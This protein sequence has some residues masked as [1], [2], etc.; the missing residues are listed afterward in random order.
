VFARWLL[1]VGVAL[2]ALLTTLPNF[3]TDESAPWWP[4]WLPQKTL[5][6]GL[7]LQ[8]GAHLALEVDLADLEQ[9]SY[10]N[11]E[12]Q[13][14]TIL[15]QEQLNYRNLQTRNGTV[16][17]EAFKPEQQA[18]VERELKRQLRDADVRR[19]GAT[20]T[21]TFTEQFLTQLRARALAQT[22]EIL[23]G[24]VDE[25]GVA[26]PLIQQQGERRIIVQLPGIEDIARA[27]GIIGRTAQ[28]SFYLV[29]REVDPYG[30]IPPGFKVLHEE[31]TDPAS[32]EVT[33]RLPYV[34]PQRP[35]LTGEYLTGAT[36][37]FDQFGQPAVMMSFDGR[38]T[39]LFARL[40]SENVGRQFAIVLDGVVYSAPVFNEAILGGRAQI[41]GNF[42]VQE[43]ED[44]ATV[45]RAGALPAPVA[46]VEERTVGPSLG[47][48]SVQA[49]LLAIMIGFVLVL[50]V[51][52]IFYF[53]YGLM[54]NTALL[55][56]VLLIT[57][58]MSM[59]GATLTLPGM[60]G[61]VL[62][63]GIAVDANVLIFERIREELLGG[64]SPR[65]AIQGGFEKALSTIVDANITTLMTA[66]IL[67]AVGSGPLRGFALT[68]GIGILAS[69]F[70]AIVLTRLLMESWLAVR[71]PK[72]ISL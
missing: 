53:G 64:R 59:L 14:R 40:S 12:A 34:V 6:L 61:I 49:G 16:T 26:E 44:L 58:V 36:A 63:I 28:L 10:E 70:T 48:D 11:L 21:L 32:G 52:A 42:T 38:G 72:Q 62:T 60:A 13:V 50:G 22:V 51:M 17:L 27:K 56:N 5:T 23:R 2:L 54:A 57:G 7:D 15:R 4:N 41:T 8:G 67:F 29:N 55:V 20:V 65:G 18:E 19:D 45:L 1:V 35:N 39:Q 33:Q 31:F 43:A 66:V 3:L 68:L 30:Q 46:V 9:R 24:R 25:F 47:A 71:Q 37:E 69:M